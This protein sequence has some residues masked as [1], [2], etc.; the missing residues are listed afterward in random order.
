VI[1]SM[2][3]SIVCGILVLAGRKSCGN[4]SRGRRLLKVD[5]RT[6]EREGTLSDNVDCNGNY[7][8]KGRRLALYIYVRQS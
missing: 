6:V 8:A 3:G 4:G 1:I 7:G 2:P 5:A